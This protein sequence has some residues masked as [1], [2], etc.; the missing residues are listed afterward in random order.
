MPSL[1]GAA[2]GAATG[3][4]FGG[5]VGAG[6]GGLIGLFKGG[7]KKPKA[8]AAG[9]GTIDP[10]SPEGQLQKRAGQLQGKA[11]VML[12]QGMEDLGQASD[13]Y[14][15]LLG[16]D[17]GALMEATKSERGRVIDQYDTARQAITEFGPRGG[18]TTSALAS[19]RIQQGNQISDL[20]SQGKQQA[21][22]GLADI[23][24]VIA[25]VGLTQEQIASMDTNAV[26]DA[27]LKREELAVTK[28]GQKAALWGG[29]AEAGAGLFGDWIS[30]RKSDSGTGTV[31]R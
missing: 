5:P 28:S 19:S 15:D 3:M 22:A 30:S 24:Q 21:A 27:V 18:G 29:L 23:G 26:L 6:I 31:M 1:S 11:D 8:P 14:G 13:Y 7:K 10:N 4:K 2:S 12:G 25:G 20:M 9:T 17:P 16:G